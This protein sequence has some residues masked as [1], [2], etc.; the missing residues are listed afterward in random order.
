[1]GWVEFPL[2]GFRALSPLLSVAH[3]L[4]PPLAVLPLAVVG[5]VRLGTVGEVRGFQL[6]EQFLPSLVAE[7]VVPIT[8]FDACAIVHFLFFLFP[9]N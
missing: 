9:E 8:V 5:A 2:Q 3:S 1:M 6:Q 4:R 7:E